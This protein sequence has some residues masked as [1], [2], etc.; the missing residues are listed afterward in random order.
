MA[1]PV[2]IINGPNLN[3]LGIREPEIYGTQTLDEIMKLCGAIASELDLTTDFRQSNNEGEIVDWV[4]ES[5]LKHSSIIINAGAY[6]H[7]SIAI[8]DALR[9]ITIPIIEVHLSNIYQR[10]PYRQISYISK[11]A[12][13]VIC[14]F[15]SDGYNLALRAVSKL[16]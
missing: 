6:S 1:K 10:E 4:Q 2:L 14:G 3:Q 8:L 16:L 15:G 13:G 5:A 12:K 9:N 11:A 7:T